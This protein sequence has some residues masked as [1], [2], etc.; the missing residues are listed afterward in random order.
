MNPA[1]INGGTFTMTGP[2]ATPVAGVVT[3][4]GST[5]TFTPTTVLANSTV[6]TATVTTGT[7]DP[8]GAPL[9]ANFVWTFTTAAP[10]TVISTVPARGAT[11]VPLNQKIAATFNTPMNA[12]TITA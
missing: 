5:A 10:P 12:S 2:G 8:T 4:A 3:Y 11:N 9:A 7:K 1:T 6:F